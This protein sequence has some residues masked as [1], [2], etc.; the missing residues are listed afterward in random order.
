MMREK[1]TIRDEESTASLTAY[2]ADTAFTAYTADTTYET[3]T[4]DNEMV[5]MTV[6]KAPE[7]DS[8]KANI[9]SG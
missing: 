1:N 6:H 9:L 7:L 3:R 8:T 5:T 2:T 4:D